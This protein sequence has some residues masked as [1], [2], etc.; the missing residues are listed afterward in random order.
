MSF[1][2]FQ[3]SLALI[4]AFAGFSGSTVDSLL[5]ATVQYSGDSGSVVLGVCIVST[6]CNCTVFR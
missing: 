2:S 6:W 4:G 5:G 3:W 1:F